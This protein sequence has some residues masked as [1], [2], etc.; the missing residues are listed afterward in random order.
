MSVVT[1]RTA[2]TMAKPRVPLR[3][4]VTTI[5]HG[6]TTWAFSISSAMWAA[7]SHPNIAKTLPMRPMKND[8]P[9][10]DH[11]PPLKNCVKTSWAEALFGARSTTGIKTAKNPTTCKTK[12]KISILGSA[13]VAAVLMNTAMMIM[14]QRSKVPCHNSGT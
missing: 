5:D 9:C 3:R 14:A 8:R 1:K 13:L 6:T 11:P 7:L 4:V 10:E 12:M 2:M